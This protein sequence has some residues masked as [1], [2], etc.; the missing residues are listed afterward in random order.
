MKRKI[1][2][3]LSLLSGIFAYT[4]AQ[5][6]PIS[7][8]LFRQIRINFITDWE[9]FR[10]KKNPLLTYEETHTEWGYWKRPSQVKGLLPD[11][12]YNK[13]YEPDIKVYRWEDIQKRNLYC[14]HVRNPFFLRYRKG[15]WTNCN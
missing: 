13:N 5:N 10:M 2:L 8:E 7:E 6:L 4:K 11:S 12:F 15:R 1:I 3:I 14:E 9:Y